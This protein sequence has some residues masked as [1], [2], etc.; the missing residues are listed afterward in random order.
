MPV[1]ALQTPGQY[2][3]QGPATLAD[4]FVLSSASFA[5]GLQD[6]SVGLSMQPCFTGERAVAITGATASPVVEDAHG[7]RTGTTYD[8]V[9]NGIRVR[10]T[11][12]SQ[13]SDCV[14]AIYVR[15]EG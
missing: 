15:K 7:V 12:G 9:R 1:R 5:P 8:A 4:G 10:F 6:I 2:S 13:R 3:G 11:T 14:K